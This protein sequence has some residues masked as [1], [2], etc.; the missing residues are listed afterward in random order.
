MDATRPFAS[1]IRA[2]A[3][4]GWAAAGELAGLH[5]GD[6]EPGNLPQA[7]GLVGGILG[8]CELPG[9]S[10]WDEVRVRAAA[11]RLMGFCAPARAMQRVDG[12]GLNAGGPPGTPCWWPKPVLA[13]KWS[14]TVRT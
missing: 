6:R 4:E 3:G 12:S 2:G 9:P 1:A 11:N 7:A 8:A 13:L 10:D 14:S 5:A